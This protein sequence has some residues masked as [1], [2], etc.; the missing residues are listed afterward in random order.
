MFL[1]S[2]ITIFLE[3]G[4][5]R[6]LSLQPC[7]QDRGVSNCQTICLYW[8]LVICPRT[9]HICNFQEKNSKGTSGR[10]W[11][12]FIVVN[13]IT[14]ENL[15]ISLIRIP[16]GNF[17]LKIVICSVLRHITNVP[18]RQIVRHTP[19]PPTRLH[20]Q[21]SEIPTFPKNENDAS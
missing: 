20:T 13:F 3:S 21:P 8:T 19:A 6:W 9:L 4:N 1:R 15:R 5:F 17:F 11:Q 2:I 18:N 16:L 7:R 14:M 12:T 10:I